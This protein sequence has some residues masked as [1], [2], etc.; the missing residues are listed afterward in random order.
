MTELYKL[1][2][3]LA[4]YETLSSFLLVLFGQR[5][6]SA[7][8]FIALALAVLLDALLRRWK[9]REGILL[10]LPL[11]LPVA[12]FFFRPSLSQILQL[13][14]AWAYVSWSI[15]TDRVST[16]YEDFKSRFGFSLRMLLILNVGIFSPSNLG[17]AAL[18]TIPYLVLMLVVGVCLLRMLREKRP[19]GV[20][21]GLYMSGFMLLCAGL[22][23]GRAPQLLVAALSL[24]YRKLIAPLLFGLAM[25]FAGL[26]YV[27]YFVLEWLA[28][29]FG[30]NEDPPV[31][32][33][34]GVAEMMGLDDTMQ[35]IAPSHPWMRYV[36]IALGAVLIAL[37]VFFLFR[38]LMG[39]KAK[40][41]GPSP[42]QE[43]REKSAPIQRTPRLSGPFRPRDPR[44]AVRFYFARFL[45]ECRRRGLVL[46]KGLTAE[47]VADY[48]SHSFP[49][50]DPMKLVKLYRPARYS[51]VQ[52]VTRED[53]SMASQAW[54]E[55]KKTST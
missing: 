51:E 22:T 7:V 53:V 5:G 31:L 29:H 48:C 1:V 2:F 49:G 9:K 34:E 12:A 19:E 18:R 43:Y 40:K 6:P 4:L 8:G 10:Y 30:S 50:A 33:M 3:D 20:R 45:S 13:L 23:L 28:S 38:R 35:E 46:P 37:L 15:L 41:E 42:Y 36:W 25:A 17:L 14:P 55:L 44:L 26:F 24:F 47:E 21:Q 27:I 16:E 54:N 32:E 39:Q 52:P 11:L